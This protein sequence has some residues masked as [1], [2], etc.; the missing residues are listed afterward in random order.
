MN[1]IQGLILA[2]LSALA[3]PLGCSSAPPRAAS[4]PNGEEPCGGGCVTL[5]NNSANCGKCGTS[6]A[7]GSAC[8]S[9]SCAC[10]AGALNCNGQCLNVSVDPNNCGGCGTKCQSGQL[11]TANG[12]ASSCQCAAGLMSCASSC[13]DVS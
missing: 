12:A 13:V 2:C 11:C 8:V 9:G 7:V 10:Q 5:A 4:C 3:L 1:R 6:C